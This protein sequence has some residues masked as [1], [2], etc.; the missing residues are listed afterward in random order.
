MKFI[1]ALVVY[2]TVAVAAPPN[3]AD[4]Q[5]TTINQQNM[6]DPQQNY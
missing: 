2:A 3:P 5:A 4:V 6:I 1:V